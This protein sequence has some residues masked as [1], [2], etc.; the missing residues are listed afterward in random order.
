MR[1]E[2]KVT[3]D[4]KLTLPAEVRKALSLKSGDKVEFFQDH[5]GH[6][7]MHS[8]NASFEGAVGLLKYEGPPASVKDMNEGIAAAV[9]DDMDRVNRQSRTRPRSRR[10]A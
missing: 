6:W 5:E 2:A 7:M 3:A 10:T 9:S 1:T 8:R 4:G